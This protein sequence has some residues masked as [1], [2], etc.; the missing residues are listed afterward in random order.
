M[1]H[2]ATDR[3]R[4][5]RV[6]VDALEVALRRMRLWEQESPDAVR[7]AS[8]QPFSFDTLR[9]HQWL[10]WQLIPRMRQILDGGGVLPT[11][12]AIHPYAEECVAELGEDPAEL[13][14]LIGHFDALI[15]GESPGARWT[16]SRVER[17][18][19]APVVTRPQKRKRPGTFAAAGLPSG[20]ALSGGRQSSIK[21][22]A[23]DPT[24]T[25]DA[26]R[27]A[28]APRSAGSARA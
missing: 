8:T 4:A 18:L 12:S 2:T 22:C 9:F 15:R 14:F 19:V 11:A 17:Q 24:A 27:S 6:V 23:A 10:Q 16:L 7:L 3:D 5:L 21:S 26:A 13:L 28:F 1:T 25:G 20:S